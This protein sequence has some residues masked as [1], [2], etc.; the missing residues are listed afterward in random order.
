MKNSTLIAVALLVA[1]TAMAEENGV[2]SQPPDPQPDAHID[3]QPSGDRHQTIKETGGVSVGEITIEVRT[4]G[5]ILN[6]LAA[7]S[8]LDLAGSGKSIV[9]SDVVISGDVVPSAY[10]PSG[11]DAEQAE[12]LEIA[13]ALTAK[14]SLN[15]SVDGHLLSACIG[16]NSSVVTVIGQNSFVHSTR[17]DDQVGRAQVEIVGEHAPDISIQWSETQ[18]DSGARDNSAPA[19]RIP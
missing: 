2:V 6:N 11:T 12:A 19:P 4:E 1:G 7:T 9:A 15:V 18:K 3:A 14:L 13:E 10:W 8:D 16:N 17:C 5:P